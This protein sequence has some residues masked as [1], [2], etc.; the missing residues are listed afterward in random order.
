MFPKYFVAS[1]PLVL[2]LLIIATLVLQY[3]GATTSSLSWC[4]A[5]YD[6][7]YTNAECL[8]CL[9]AWDDAEGAT[10]DE[11]YGDYEYA[12]DSCSQLSATPCCYAEFFSN[13]CLG[14]SAFVEYWTCYIDKVSIAVGPGG[15]D[16]LTCDGGIEGTSGVRST[17]PG[18]MLTVPGL[19]FLTAVSILAV[20]L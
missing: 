6:V 10:A 15:C 9:Q 7:C 5:E 16:D 11:C 12:A 17:S 13:D 18:A 4:D 14:N 19:A 3:T 20:L 8:E 2:L 1:G